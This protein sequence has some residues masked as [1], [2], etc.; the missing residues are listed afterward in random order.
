MIREY[1]IDVKVKRGMDMMQS[2]TSRRV[3]LK[4]AVTLAGGL[5]LD[6]ALPA[7]ALRR[8]AGGGQA[9]WIALADRAETLEPILIAQGL[10]GLVLTGATD[11]V[12]LGAR[13]GESFE[14]RVKAAL[15][16]QHRFVEV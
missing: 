6:Q 5:A 12:R 3:V 11:R 4:S 2:R 15:D 10:A 9:A 1:V 14:R 8:Y 13:A 7:A 16:P